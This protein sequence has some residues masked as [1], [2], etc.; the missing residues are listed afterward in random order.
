[1]SAEEVWSD[2]TLLVVWQILARGWTDMRVWI[3]LSGE[4][5]VWFVESPSKNDLWDKK[6]V[7]ETMEH[8]SWCVWGTGEC[9]VLSLNSSNDV[10][11]WGDTH[12]LLSRGKLMLKL[13]ENAG[14]FEKLTGTFCKSSERLSKD[15]SE[16]GEFDDRIVW[17]VMCSLDWKD[18]S[19]KK[20]SGDVID[21]EY[22]RK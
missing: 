22:F 7:S 9:R 16:K 1:M 20:S 19:D 3:S 13:V 2:S 8:N 5:G 6:M 10:Y 11:D 18:K 12:V 21:W 4:L 14:L 15:I 17:E